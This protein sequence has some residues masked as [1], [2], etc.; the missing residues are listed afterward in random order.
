MNN[1]TQHIE[2]ERLLRYLL[3][4][5]TKDETRLIEKWLD[6]SVQN[7]ELLDELERTWLE[8][9]KLNPAPIAVN[10]DAAWTKIH[11]RITP[12]QIKTQRLK[13]KNRR[14]LPR[15]IRIAAAIVLFIGLYQ[16]FTILNSS[17]QIILIAEL[18]Q[19]ND[20]LPDGSKVALNK[21]STLEVKKGF[22]SETREVKLQG[23]AFFDIQ[24]NP[25]KPF[26][27]SAGGSFIK[28]LGTS[29][30]VQA[31]PDSMLEVFVKSGV[32]NLYMIDELTGDTASVI[33]VAGEKGIVPRVSKRPEKVSKEP[34]ELFWFNRT[35]VFKE[36]KLKKVVELL[37]KY[38]N[39]SIVA[40]ADLL[41]N[42]KLS[43]TFKD[44]SIEHIL[45][46]IASSLEL[47]LYKDS[48]TYV[49]EKN[50]TPVEK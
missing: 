42:S 33:L 48:T 15:I 38:Y 35:L 47:K 18:E 19:V 49:F 29:F 7:R 36:T 43:S 14:L 31:Y 8:T 3:G 37:E 44:E 4:D 40:G 10:M 32:V 45:D 34:S 1:E 6:A 21:Q 13:K 25:D 28:V 30:N 24:A 17:K 2:E 16:V 11:K 22:N 12:D 23:E 26:I 9:G 20:S 46:V 5:I 41:E 39:V 27:I 50:D